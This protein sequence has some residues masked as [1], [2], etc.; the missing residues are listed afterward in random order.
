MPSATEFAAFGAGL[1]LSLIACAYLT[2]RSWWRRPNLRALGLLAG[3][4]VVLGWS[5]ATLLEQP[6]QAPAGGPALAL[7]PAAAVAP[8]SAGA[9]Y[10]T[11]DAVNLRSG[12]GTGSTRLAVLPAGSPV[13]VTGRREGD[14]WQVRAEIGGREWE[15]WASSLWLRRADEGRH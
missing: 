4:A 15:G 1:L 12:T 3:G 11:H 6:D 2:P 14:W 5:L 10:R 8:P 7:A 13:T 9:R